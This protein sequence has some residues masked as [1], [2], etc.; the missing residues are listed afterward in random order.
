MVLTMRAPKTRYGETLTSLKG[1]SKPHGVVQERKVRP[2]VPSAQNALSACTQQ[3]Q[4]YG[5]SHPVWYPIKGLGFGGFGFRVKGS[6][7]TELKP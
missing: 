6:G 3:S 4:I 2:W 1:W 7:G 5:N